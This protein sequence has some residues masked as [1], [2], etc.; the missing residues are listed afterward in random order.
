MQRKKIKALVFQYIHTFCNVWLLAV[1][2]MGSPRYNDVL[3]WCHQQ[4][5]WAWSR[6]CARLHTT[7]CA[8]RASAAASVTTSYSFF[9]FCPSISHKEMMGS[10][11]HSS[12]TVCLFGTHA[13]SVTGPTVWNSLPDHLR[14]PAVDSEQFR[15]DL[16]T[17]LFAGHLKRYRIR[18]VT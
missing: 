15:R 5:S 13:F 16:K 12:T 1:E 9:F 10:K 4:R 11:Q 8:A 7:W 3:V 17:C 18:G 14:N 2:G 6:C